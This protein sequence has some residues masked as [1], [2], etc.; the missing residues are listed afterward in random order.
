MWERSWVL[1]RLATIMTTNFHFSML[2]YGMLLNIGNLGTDLPEPV[3]I[4]T[5]DDTIDG[6]YITPSLK[7]YDATARVGAK[8]RRHYLVSPLY[9][10]HHAP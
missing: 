6:S 2:Y 8:S 4:A 1:R 5:E 3:V 7:D 9:C 10:C